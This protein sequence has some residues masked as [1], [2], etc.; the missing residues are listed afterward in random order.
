MGELSDQK[1]RGSTG[2]GMMAR[3]GGTRLKPELP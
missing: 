1:P 2:P 3:P